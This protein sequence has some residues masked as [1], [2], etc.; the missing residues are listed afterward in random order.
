MSSFHVLTNAG[1]HLDIPEVRTIGPADLI[2]AL[3]LGWRD[4]WEKPSHL[5]FLGLIYPLCGAIL[6]V[7][8]SGNRI[9]ACDDP[10]TLLRLA[11]C[12]KLRLG[13]KRAAALVGRDEAGGI[14]P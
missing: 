5:A 1:D 8:T 2:D 10:G 7:W 6:A 13:A 11:E 14:A 12:L 9:F 4:F 3:R